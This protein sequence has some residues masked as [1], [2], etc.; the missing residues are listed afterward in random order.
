MAVSA[1]TRTIVRERAR[2]FCEYC[3]ADETWQFVRF[4][5]DHIVP[6]SNGGSDAVENLALACRN[7]NERRSNRSEGI[8]PE[9]GE[10]V[11]IFNPRQ[12]NWHQHF[13]WSQDHLRLI[14]LTPCG[15]A[16]IHLLDLNDDRH[17]N[18]VIRIRQRDIDDGLHPPAKMQ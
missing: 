9:T 11:F 12:Q 1:A 3:C 7:C 14:G 5:I 10:S 13:A 4:T 6:R 8:D 15:R 17:D 18:V 2:G 16:T